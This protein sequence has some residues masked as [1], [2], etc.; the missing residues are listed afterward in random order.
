MTRM[1]DGAL[2]L[3]AAVAVGLTGCGQAAATPRAEAES[4]PA[5]VQPV[6]GTEVSSIELTAEAADRLGIG[7]RTVGRLPAAA[8][9]GRDGAG[10]ARL[11]IPVSALV[12]DKDGRTWVFAVTG[13]RTFMRREVTVARISGD[14]AILTAG[15]PEGTPVVV[16][17]A[18]ELLGAEYGVA[19]E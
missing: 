10:A 5:M 1:R 13:E 14:V 6:D 16:V 17:G 18:A 15:P 7:T 2:L 4:G 12:Y 8:A 19:G 9:P 11:Q 3:L